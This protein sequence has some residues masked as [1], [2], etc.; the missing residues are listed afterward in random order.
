MRTLFQDIRC[1]LRMS[2][3]SSAVTVVAV[4]AAVLC[5][6]ANTSF[7]SGV[8]SMLRHPRHFRDAASAAVIW[9]PGR[10]MTPGVVSPANHSNWKGRNRVFGDITAD[11]DRARVNLTGAGEPEDLFAGEVTANFFQMIGV[12]PVLGRSFSPE[13]DQ[14]GH[15]RV[16]IL[17]HALWRR[18]FASDTGVIG[19]SIV[20]NG[21]SHQVIGILPRDFCWN[22][23]RTDVWVPY[24]L[25]S[26]RDERIAGERYMRVASGR[27]QNGRARSSE[28]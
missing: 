9:R 1:R 27:N 23:R 21:E 3:Q 17:S 16:A 5:I 20:L 15:D 10:S 19:R 25:D 6:T 18:R 13:E 8:Y 24:L 28:I 12:Q 4:L 26:N 11:V 2:L 7:F 22:N 14:R